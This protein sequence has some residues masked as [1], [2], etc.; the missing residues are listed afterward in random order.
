MPIIREYRKGLQGIIHCTGGAYTK[1]L[2]FISPNVEVHIECVSPTLILFEMIRTS[3][4]TSLSEMYKVFNMGIRMLLFVDQKSAST[5]LDLAS[6]FGVKAYIM[7][8]VRKSQD[9][10]KVIIQTGDEA[11]P[12]V[13]YS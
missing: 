5:I 4:N 11:E 7:G 8:Q 3:S 12:I 13:E 2:K 10:A 1:A 9:A 6:A